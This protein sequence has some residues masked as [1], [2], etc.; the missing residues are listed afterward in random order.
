MK[1]V[2][3]AFA[4]EDKFARDNLVHQS[5][6]LHTPFEFL[7]MSVQEPFTSMWKTQCRERIKECQGV[8]AFISRNT[9]S[10]TGACW[11]MQT[12]IDEGIP[13]R[14]F[15]VHK[16]DLCCKPS[17]LGSTRVDYWTWDNVKSFI[18]SL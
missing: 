10:A 7:D 11:E 15:W 18:D 13:I 14:G 9:P 4:I 3:I 2:F 12:A 1:K 8:V 16:D 17:E 5:N 6:Q